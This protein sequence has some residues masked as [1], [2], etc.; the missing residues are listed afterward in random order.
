MK[1]IK[2][3][4][5]EIQLIQGSSTH[6]E[7]ANGLVLMSVLSA[8][9]AGLAGFVYPWLAVLMFVLCLVCLALYFENIAKHDKARYKVKI[10]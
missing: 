5:K 3:D 1:K 6:L 7:S 2:D 9:S 8:V 10:K 4:Y